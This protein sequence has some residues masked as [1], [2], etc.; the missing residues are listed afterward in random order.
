VAN[1]ETPPPDP[2]AQELIELAREIRERV[3]SRHPTHAPGGVALPDLMPLLHARDAAEGKVA[4][5]G[6]VNPRPPGALNSLI[7]LLKRLAARLLDWHV[8][9]QVEFNRSVVRALSATLEA[10][11]ENNRALA[12][13]AEAAAAGRDVAAHWAQWRPAWEEKLEKSE[14][15]A[16]RA[17][18]E[19]QG[20]VQQRL[21][22]LEIS[23]R[24]LTRRQHEEFRLSAERSALEIQ[25]RLWQDLEKVRI[26][27]ERLIHSELRLLR[28]RAAR[29]D[30]VAPPAAPV[31]Q[32]GEPPVD[33]L[34]FALRFRGSEEEIRRRQ[35]FYVPYFRG[36]GQVLDLACGRGEFLELLREAGVNAR[37]VDLDPACVE[38]CRAKGLDVE[39]RG[40]FD[41]L[42]QLP[43]S[44][45]DAI[46]CSHFVE[47]LPA[48]QV[49]ELIRLASSRLV[50][51]GLL[52]VETPNPQC[53]ATLATAFYADPTH[54]RPLPASL[55]RFYFE[56]A[57]FGGIEVHPLS[58]ASEVYPELAALPD[59]F[60]DAFFGGMDYA[61]LGRRL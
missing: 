12:R 24:D 30:P 44:T 57:G 3:R 6:T 34:A 22:Q 7:Q 43:P 18:A 36:A 20:V 51:G 14:I 42:E 32:A 40:A 8:R 37:G 46:F 16:L 5:I 33:P 60:R 19:L 4:S 2:T 35:T 11:D 49:P 31:A 52:A 27:F 25:Q 13:I 10:L 50:P 23:F 9:E 21:A 26:E 59:A 41:C 17:L 61:I 47:H 45:L 15:H 56:E 48:A 54:Q 39:Q 28:Q 38:I 1:G 29:L 55:L 58:P 53:L